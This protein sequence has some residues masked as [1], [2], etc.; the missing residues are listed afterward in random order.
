MDILMEEWNRVKANGGAGGID[1]IAI[2]D[3]PLL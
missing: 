2:V 3:V 1:G